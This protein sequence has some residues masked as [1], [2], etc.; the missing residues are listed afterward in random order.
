[1]LTPN[2]HRLRVGARKCCACSE[3]Y[4]DSKGQQAKAQNHPTSTVSW[5]PFIVVLDRIDQESRHHS[6]LL[7]FE[8]TS[9]KL[10]DQS[11]RSHL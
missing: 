5:T 6:L 9:D 2:L 4:K 11:K 3:Q 1:V 7:G 10:P 8:S